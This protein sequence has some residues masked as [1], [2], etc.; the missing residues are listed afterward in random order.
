VPFEGEG[1]MTEQIAD[2]VHVLRLGRGVASANVYLVRSGSSWVL[3]DTGWPGQADTITAA[4]EALFGHAAPAVIL[5]THLHPDHRGSMRE[6]A[7][8]WEVEVYVHRD[9]LPFASG[10][11][12][13]RFA[14]PLDRWVLGPVLARLPART[15]ARVPAPADVTGLV[16]PLGGD[17]PGL[18]DWTA[19][20]T[21]GHTPGHVAYHR[22][23]DGVLI[24]GDA[25]LTVDVNSLRGVLGGRQRIGGPPRCTTWSPPAATA[26]IRALAA[27]EPAVLAP[28]HGRPM[29]SGTAAAVHE[30]A[31]RPDAN[32][33][34]AGVLGPVDY[35]A[36]RRY[37]RSP[38]LYRRLQPLGWLLTGLGL[39]PGYAVVLEV[40]GRRTGVIRRTQLVRVDLDGEHYLVSL[41]GESEWVR[42]VRAAGGRVVLG[43]RERRAATLVELPPAERPPVIRAYLHRAGARGRSWGRAGEARYYF[44]VNAEPSD[45]QL[46]GVADR[47]PVFHVHYGPS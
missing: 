22:P 5:L 36:P 26:S 32:R 4:A 23:R 17:V 47:Y 6:L 14:N 2:G 27:L 34:L 21:P 31:E 40:P 20:P 41:P 43:R 45:G 1:A 24:S 46:R 18:P 12:Q 8:R 42:N 25:L 9:E 16:H 3:V 19:V 13:P 44:G 38:R 28:G 7:A 39:T 11:Y 15:R 10:E 37:R 30:F 35:A 29:S 33:P